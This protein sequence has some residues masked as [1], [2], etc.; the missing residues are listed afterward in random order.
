MMHIVPSNSFRLIQDDE[1]TFSP[2]EWC[3]LIQVGEGSRKRSRAIAFQRTTSSA[4]VVAPQAK[5][6]RTVTPVPTKDKNQKSV[7]FCNT[8]VIIRSHQHQ[9]K[10]SND[11]NTW[12]T[13]NDYQSFKQTVKADLKAYKMA[14]NNKTK[15]NM[16]VHCLRG[17]EKYIQPTINK[18]HKEQSQKRIQAV[19][20]QQLI[21]RTLDD[22]DNNKNND[23]TMSVLAQ[24]IAQSTCDMAIEQAAL[25]SMIH[26]DI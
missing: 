19:L 5:R 3:Q 12:Y 20:D 1:A 26:L 18:F 23:N 17:L 11:N 9:Q 16:K 25:D 6:A 24:I 21:Q 22:V 13:L 2:L 4:T 14:R 15:M 10:D 7:S 8:T